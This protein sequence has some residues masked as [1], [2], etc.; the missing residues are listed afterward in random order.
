MAKKYTISVTDNPD[1]LD[2]QVIRQD[3]DGHHAAHTSPVDWLPLGAFMRDMEGNI[4]AGVMGGS[5][6]GWL[7][8][9][10]VWV[11]DPLRRRNY[12]LRLLKEVEK[13]AVQR[14][15][16]HAFIETQDYESMLFYESIGYIVTKKSEESGATRYS[17]QRELYAQRPIKSA[18]P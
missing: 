6:W 18:Q 13:E 1:P 7:Y 8:I 9:S 16:E 2:L 5:Y 3:S 17:M 4:I 10:M 11:K 15:C 12:S 14:G